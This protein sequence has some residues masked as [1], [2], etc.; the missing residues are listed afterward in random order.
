MVNCKNKN[1]G[2]AKTLTADEKDDHENQCEFRMISCFERECKPMKNQLAITS[3]KEHYESN[4]WDRK[5]EIQVTISKSSYVPRRNS[6]A[7]N[8]Q[9]ICK[10]CL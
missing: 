5:E 3:F 2:C 1:F 4:H 8:G 10:M 6:L 7:L 9:T